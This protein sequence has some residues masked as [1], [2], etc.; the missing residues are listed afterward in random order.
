MFSIDNYMYMKNY[1]CTI[2]SAQLQ[3]HNYKCTLTNVQ[4]QVYNYEYNKN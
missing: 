2:T 1:K 4:L 3:V